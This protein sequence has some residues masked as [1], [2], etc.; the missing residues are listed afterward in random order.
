MTVFTEGRH[1][2][3]FVL[4]EANGQRSR[5]TASAGGSFD[6]GEVL[7]LSGSD[8]VSYNGSGTVVGVALYA[9]ESGDEVAY[10]GRD[11]EVNGKLL[12]S[13]EQTDGE[14]QAAAITGLKALHV[15][16]R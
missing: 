14:I 11:A 6:V 12:T 8:L 16:V 3:E 15:I 2:A 1:P 4:S 7:K 5:D 13:S 10:I 9:A